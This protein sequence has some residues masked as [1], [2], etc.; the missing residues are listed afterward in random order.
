LSPAEGRK[1][2]FTVGIAFLVLGGVVLWRGHDPVATAFGAVGGLLLLAG[3]VIPGKLGPVNRAWMGFALLLSKFT[4]PIFMGVTYFLV[5]SPIGVL[6][7]LFGKNPVVRQAHDGSFWV[8]RAEGA[9]RK[10]DLNRQF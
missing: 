6:M 4:T 1:F 8:P 3:I 7:R 2:A 9:K 10:S 5:L